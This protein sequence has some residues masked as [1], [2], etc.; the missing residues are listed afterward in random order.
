M[1]ITRLAQY[2]FAKISS[3]YSELTSELLY[4]YSYDILFTLML[5]YIRIF[6]A[7]NLS[8][9]GMESATE[10]MS[11][12]AVGTIFF[13]HYSFGQGLTLLCTTFAF[14]GMTIKGNEHLVYGPYMLVFTIIFTLA[15]LGDYCIERRLHNEDN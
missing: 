2:G 10:R 8:T 6:I 15:I 1:T 14:K 7:E 3:P 4:G 11:P 12:L 5:K 9:I 13:A